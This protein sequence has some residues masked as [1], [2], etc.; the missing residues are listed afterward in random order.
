ML[1]QYPLMAATTLEEPTLFD[2]DDA[3]FAHWIDEHCDD[4]S[5]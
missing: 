2:Q 4:G 1:P 5:F 3:G